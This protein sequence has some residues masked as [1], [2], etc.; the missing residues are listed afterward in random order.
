MSEY[1][2]PEPT[3]PALSGPDSAPPNRAESRPGTHFLPSPSTDEEWEALNRY[4]VDVDGVIAEA[5][6]LFR[7]SRRNPRSDAE[8]PHLRARLEAFEVD[9]EQRND[10]GSLSRLRV[11]KILLHAPI[12]R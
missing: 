1:H 10:P 8:W 12:R 5:R 11:V 7:V 6:Q 9:L 3:A 4:H 2:V